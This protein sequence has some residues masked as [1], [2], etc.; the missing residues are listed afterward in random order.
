MGCQVRTRQGKFMNC[1]SRFSVLLLTI[2][3]AG[4]V[5]SRVAAEPPKITILKTKPVGTDSAP[6]AAQQAEFDRVYKEF[7]LQRK[8]GQHPEAERLGN[9]LITLCEKL[10]GAS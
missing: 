3:C 10:K 8:A 1:R 2:L 7:E 6:A 9:Q 4:P 5:P